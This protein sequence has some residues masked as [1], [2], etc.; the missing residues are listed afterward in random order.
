L[1]I[2]PLKP[3]RTVRER[4]TLFRTTLLILA[5]FAGGTL[6]AAVFVGR[7]VPPPADM[8]AGA[9]PAP[10][11]VA[12]SSPPIQESMPKP[13]PR[14]VTVDKLPGQEPQTTGAAAAAPT[15]AESPVVNHQPAAAPSCNQ[16][17]CSRAYRSFDSSTCTYQPY[18]GA[19]RR[20]C[21]K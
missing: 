5:A 21:E 16:A 13:E 19:Q 12:P 15:P 7:P 8:Q 14:I 3:K 11:A 10:A 18:S 9:T 6:T 1:T 17:A 2:L 4:M 20:L